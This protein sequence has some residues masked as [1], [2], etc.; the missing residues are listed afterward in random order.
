MQKTKTKKG[1]AKLWRTTRKKAFLS[2]RVDPKVVDKNAKD[3]ALFIH[4][5]S[6]KI[7]V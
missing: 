6:K 2:Y 7:S 3:F 1:L 4:W 5:G